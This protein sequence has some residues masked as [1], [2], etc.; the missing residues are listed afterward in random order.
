MRLLLQRERS[1]FQSLSMEDSVL[2]AVEV[3][4]GTQTEIRLYREVG[5]QHTFDRAAFSDHRRGL[6]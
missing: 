6:I 1:Q 4:S 3:G 5:L 2:I